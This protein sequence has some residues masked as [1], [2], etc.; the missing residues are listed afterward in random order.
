MTKKSRQKCKYLEREKS[1]L[2]E[3]KSIF[4]HFYR[5][6]IE[7]NKTNFFLEGESPTLKDSTNLKQEKT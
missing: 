5:A 7:T 3:I 2:Y 4:R 1:F 6:F